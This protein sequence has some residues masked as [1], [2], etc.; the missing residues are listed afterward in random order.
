MTGTVVGW[1]GEAMPVRG[2]EE[3]PWRRAWTWA[4]VVLGGGTGRE[5]AGWEREAK[6]DRG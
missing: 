2:A 5:E 4:A 1:R 6:T 3:C